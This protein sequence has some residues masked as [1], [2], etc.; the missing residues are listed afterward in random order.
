MTFNL[1]EYIYII[2][3]IGAWFIAQGLKALISFKHHYEGNVSWQRLVA[4]GGMPSSHVSLVTTMAIL[5]GL[6]EGFDTAIFG[7]M[8]TL[9]GIVI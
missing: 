3:A 7:L 1:V 4:S 2:G 6:V 9:S 5:I 8:F